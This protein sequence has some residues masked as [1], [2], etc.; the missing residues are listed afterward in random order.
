MVWDRSSVE[1]MSTRQRDS[2]I[3]SKKVVEP[4]G[5]GHVGQFLLTIVVNIC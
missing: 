1:D 2:G 4:L 5:N 3:A